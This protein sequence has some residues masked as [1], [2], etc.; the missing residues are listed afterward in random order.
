[1]YASIYR[2]VSITDRYIEENTLKLF[3]K[4]YNCGLPDRRP[5]INLIENIYVVC[6]FKFI[7]QENN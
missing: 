6:I 2:C 4:D 5:D 7:T 3:T 1:M